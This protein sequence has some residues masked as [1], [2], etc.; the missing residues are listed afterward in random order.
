MKEENKKLYTKTQDILEEI[1]KSK[2]ANRIKFVKCKGGTCSIRFSG[3]TVIKCGVISIRIDEQERT[4]PIEEIVVIGFKKDRDMNV[5]ENNVSN[6]EYVFR[7]ADTPFN[8]FNVA[9]HKENDIIKVIN[10]Y[11]DRLLNA[12]IKNQVDQ[13]GRTH[14]DCENRCSHH[15][16]N[17]EKNVKINK[18]LIE[19]D[20]NLPFININE[21]DSDSNGE[22]N[23][24][25]MID[26]IKG[27]Y[28]KQK[29]MQDTDRLIRPI[30]SPLRSLENGSKQRFSEQ[31]LKQNFIH[32]L[33]K[34][35]KVN[36]NGWSY[37][38]ETPTIARY[39]F[40][41]SEYPKIASRCIDNEER[42]ID[43]EKNK[44]GTSARFDCTIYSQHVG[45]TYDVLSHIEFKEG[46]AKDTEI[47]KDLLK[48]ANEPFCHHLSED[49]RKIVSKYYIGDLKQKNHYFIHLIEKLDV[50][51]LLSLTCKYFGLADNTYKRLNRDDYNS[52]FNCLN[53]SDNEIYIYVIVEE[54]AFLVNSQNESSS[55]SQI[56][57]QDDDSRDKFACFRI[58]Y[59]KWL[60]SLYKNNQIDLNKVWELVD[61]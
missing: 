46:P 7:G 59:R 43:D 38:V 60:K 9:N 27:A 44:G 1:C 61:D 30:Y 41:D 24:E 56:N 29:D 42:Y 58:N 22:I 50:K 55:N 6:I 3:T 16:K 19:F 10:N 57:N 52:I 36:K 37:S 54:C 45:D 15:K 33:S 25:P 11:L 2:K 53:E 13:D 20:S 21:A 8:C 17:Q 23:E 35:I 18:G 47:T 39:I 28:Q 5:L 31:E 14:Q 49:E 34:N 12:K 40:K 51:S 32:V 4:V 26:Y 48:L